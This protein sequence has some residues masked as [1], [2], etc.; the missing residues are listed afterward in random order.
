MSDAKPPPDD[1]PQDH[2]PPENESP[3]SDGEVQ[4][5]NGGIAAHLTSRPAWLRILFIVLFIA[6]WGISKLIVFAVIILQVLFLL[7]T[8]QRNDRL[9][10]FGGNLASYI[11]Q[12]VAYLTFAS[13]EQPFPF[14]EWPSG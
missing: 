7:V 9:A 12:L 6:I 8:G 4:D 2:V 1:V 3:G 14:S 11:R 13:E 10:Q 5:R